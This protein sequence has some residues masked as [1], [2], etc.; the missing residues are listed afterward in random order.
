MEDDRIPHTHG[1]DGTVLF[2]ALFEGGGGG[3]GEKLLTKSW[4]VCKKKSQDA[5][6]RL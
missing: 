2:G 6:I 5:K 1:L 3:G 4:N